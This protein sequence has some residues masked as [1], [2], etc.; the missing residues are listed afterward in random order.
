MPAV[1]LGSSKDELFRHLI[2]SMKDYAIFVL[3]PDGNVLT[4]NPGAEAF[5]IKNLSGGLVVQRSGRCGRRAP[6]S[7]SGLTA[8]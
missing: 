8:G 6:R 2:D 5:G 4:W 3:S 1:A 7:L